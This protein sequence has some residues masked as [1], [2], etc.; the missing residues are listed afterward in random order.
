MRKIIIYIGA[1]FLLLLLVWVVFRGEQK[2]EVVSQTVDSRNQAPKHEKAF[3]P[4]DA[5]KD[6]EKNEEGEVFHSPDP[7]LK[8]ELNNLQERLKQNLGRDSVLRL[9]REFTQK[10]FF[11]DPDA[12][13]ATLLEFLRAGGDMP[14]GLE[15]AVGEAGLEEWPSLRAFVLDLLG[16]IDLGAASQ[17]ALTTVIPAESSTVE[18]AVALRIFWLDGGA[19]QATPELISSWFRLFRKTSWAEQPDAAWM[20]SLDF[21]GRMPTTLPDFITEASG[22]LADPAASSGKAEAAQLALERSTRNHPVETLSALLENPVWLG[23]GRGPAVRAS[24][25]ARLDAGDPAQADL[26]GRYLASLD[27]RSREAAA[28]FKAFPYR[29]FSVSPGLSGLPDLQTKEEIIA[30]NLAAEAFFQ[31]IIVNG[32]FPLLQD[33][34]AQIQLRL[35][36]LNN[37]R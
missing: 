8:A 19:E 23:K 30:S 36:E 6:L 3:H 25:F 29:T 10:A 17:Y 1:G 22:W 12:A 2:Q 9:L 31:G 28:F 14:T 27:P 33:K 16:K 5:S 13:A 4:K 37:R 24:L 7:V 26:L 11:A 35:K 32:R 20:E 21:V 15:F 34:I 18:Y